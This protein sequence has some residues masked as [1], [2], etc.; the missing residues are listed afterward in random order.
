MR[1]TI[2][3]VQNMKRA[4]EKIAM[5]T[6]YD[7]ASA[8]IA[9]RAG[10]PMILVGDSLGMVMLGHD[11]TLPV[12]LNDMIRHAGAVMRAGERALVVADL[13]FLTYATIEDAVLAVRRL[14]QE[15]GVHAVKLEGGQTIVPIVRKLV[16]LG[17]PVMGHLGLTPQ[18][19]HQLGLRVQA[20]HAAEARQLLEDALALQAAGA[21][22]IVLEVVPAPLGKAVSERLNIPVIGIGAGVGCD[23]QVQ[24]WHDVLGLFDSK[25]PRHAKRYA[26][27]GLAMETAVRSY[28]DDVRSGVFPTDAQSARMDEAELA[29]ALA[30]VDVA[31]KA[32]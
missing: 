9:E 4:G 28:V 21:F 25:T 15:A 7:V 31:G 5:L 32:E 23:G 8:M 12:T 27:I 17:V 3:D 29:A 1:I 26:E 18:S 14:M 6:A 10:V 13:P 20:K 24:V 19:Q 2:A 11:T 16:E 22:A 30:A